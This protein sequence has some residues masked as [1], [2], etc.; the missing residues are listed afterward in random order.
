MST[1][2]FQ[3]VS[4]TEYSLSKSPGD[5]YSFHS[6]A[7]FK[8]SFSCIR[9]KPFVSVRKPEVP[10][11]VLYNPFDGNQGYLVDAVRIRP[12]ADL[13]FLIKME[14]GVRTLHQVFFIVGFNGQ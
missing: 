8:S 7:D 10:I 12:Q 9:Y 4:S 11:F 2:F 5:W 6:L 1:R 3:G 13:V 14:S